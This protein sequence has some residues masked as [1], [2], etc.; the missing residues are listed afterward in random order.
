M[1]AVIELNRDGFLYCYYKDAG[2]T[3]ARVFPNWFQPDPYVKGAKPMA[4]PGESIPFEIR[5]DQVGSVSNCFAWPAIATS[6]F[7]RN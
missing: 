3:I 7:R 1:R 4:F 2:H 6:P 5:F